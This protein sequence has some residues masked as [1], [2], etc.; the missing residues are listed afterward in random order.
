[1]CAATTMPV[2]RAPPG[3]R[4]AGNWDRANKIRAIKWS[5]ITSFTWPV[6]TLLGFF[7][8]KLDDKLL[9]PAT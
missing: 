1:L 4:R 9:Q 5:R 7:Q 2:F 6:F 3:D 8:G